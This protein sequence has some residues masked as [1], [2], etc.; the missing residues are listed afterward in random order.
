MSKNIEI[1]TATSEIGA[2]KRGAGIGPGAVVTELLHKRPDLDSKLKIHRIP[3]QNDKIDDITDHPYS[4]KIQYLSNAMASVTK[5]VE[6]S[7]NHGYFPLILSGDH[8]NAIGAV[9]GFRN[10]F[11]QGNIGVIWVDAHLDLHSP[12]TTP[13]GNIHGMALNA[14]LATDNTQRKRNEPDEESL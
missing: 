6:F 1:I 4:K 14:L 9:S 7:L 5:G 11:D 8:S 2:G 12:F 3:D 13:S 10:H